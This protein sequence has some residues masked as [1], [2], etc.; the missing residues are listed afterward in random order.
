M[1]KK[2]SDHLPWELPPNIITMP[3]DIKEAKIPAN[4]GRRK[5]SHEDEID[6][7]GCVWCVWV[8]SGLV[9]SAWY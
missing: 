3:G 5:D 8:G 4:R 9:D 7:I 2:S 6:S 1:P